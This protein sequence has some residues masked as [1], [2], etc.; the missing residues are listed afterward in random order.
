[1]D[2]KGTPYESLLFCISTSYLV[3]KLTLISPPLWAS[4]SIH[5]CIL[6]PTI[7][8]EHLKDTD[9]KSDFFRYNNRVRRKTIVDILLTIRVEG[10]Y[11]EE[12]RR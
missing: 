11:N 9:R 6:Y 3:D 10:K 1:M 8:K 4:E 5:W 12:V 2:I 7:K